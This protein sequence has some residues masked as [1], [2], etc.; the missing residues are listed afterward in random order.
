MQ[1]RSHRRPS[2]RWMSSDACLFERVDLA[3]SQRELVLG[4]P[5]Q[6]IP[7]QSL[8]LSRCRRCRPD[9]PVNRMPQMPALK[10]HGLP[11][12]TKSQ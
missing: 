5:T 2:R 3:F 9:P 8:A 10:P 4:A 1:P 6:A 11:S 7:E 12:P